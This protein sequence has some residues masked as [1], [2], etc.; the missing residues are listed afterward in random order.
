MGR[1]KNRRHME[2]MLHLIEYKVHA[3]R[4]KVLLLGMPVICFNNDNHKKKKKKIS[5]KKIKKKE[6]GEEDN[7]KQNNKRSSSPHR[8]LV[9][10]KL[11]LDLLKEYPCEK[12]VK[13]KEE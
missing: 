10:P 6:E 7:S 12:K 2:E 5:D 3:L 13:E 4:L 8:Y 9:S 1:Q 11:L